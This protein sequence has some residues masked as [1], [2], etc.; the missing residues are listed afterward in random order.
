MQRNFKPSPMAVARPLLCWMLVF[1]VI[2]AVGKWW[3]LFWPCLAV[4]LFHAAFHRHPR[5]QGPSDPSVLV[6]PGDG[7]VT[8]I[9][10]IDEPKFIKGAARRV[11][12]FLSIFDVHVQPS[13]CDAKLRWV[14]YQPGTFFDARDEKC[15]PQN[16]SQALG[17]QTP[18]GMRLVVRQIAGA[19]ARRII[20]WRLPEEEV[21]RGE[22][23]GMIRYGSR[24]ELY[25]PKD[26]GEILVNVGD[27][28]LGGKT[29]ILRRK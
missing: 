14:D 1:I 4:F 23:L 10:E 2:G 15:S 9:V 26:A 21:K 11:G 22:L 25:I 19:I 13:P 17:L 6:A 3:M 20:L 12:I 7:K 28:V 16:E 29:P 24:V 18:D 8:D 5:R 27:R